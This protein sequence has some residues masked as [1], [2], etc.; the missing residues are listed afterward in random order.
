MDEQNSSVV[1]SGRQGSGQKTAERAKGAP[2]AARRQP[3]RVGDKSRTQRQPWVE[4]APGDLDAGD[5]RLSREPQDKRCER[6]RPQP[7]LSRRQQAQTCPGCGCGCG[8][9]DREISEVAPGDHQPKGEKNRAA[10]RGGPRPPDA[11]FCPQRAQN[12]RPASARD[13]ERAK[14]QIRERLKDIHE[15]SEA[16]RA[17]CWFG[18]RRQTTSVRDSGKLYQLPSAAQWLCVSCVEDARH[19]VD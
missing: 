7:R 12:D 15:T 13:A 4:R 16:S 14:S 11:G 18:W 2:G 8:G 5:H 3:Q 10:R 19:S 9:A 1:D 17:A 6:Q